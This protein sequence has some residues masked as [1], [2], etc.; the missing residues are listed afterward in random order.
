MIQISRVF[1]G[2][3][4]KGKKNYLNTQRRYELA[5]TLLLFGL[6][7]SLFIAGYLGT[8]TRLNLLTIVAVLGCLPASKSLVSLIMFCRYS[9]TPVD[10]AEKIDA[11]VGTLNCLYDLV[12][13]SR[14]KIFHVEHVTVKGT[15]VC[16]YSLEK[17]FDEKA[18][19]KHISQVLK[20]D[21]INNVS[22]K[23]FVDLAKYLNRL[24]QMQ[25]LTCDDRNSSAIMETF[26]SVSL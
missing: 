10:L 8:G 14:E 2:E 25:E 17:A 12:F 19:E 7:A 3:N 15:T 20:A 26:K 5:R 22:I 24:D 13:T 1:S 16:G 4:H 18:F 11:H 9:S 23:I 6:S 21:S